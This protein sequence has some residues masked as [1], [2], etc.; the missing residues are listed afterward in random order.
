MSA[1]Q[2]DGA[3][4]PTMLKRK[5]EIWAE[6]HAAKTTCPTCGKKL[7]FRSL[8]WKHVCRQ[9]GVTQVLLDTDLAEKRRAE[10]QQKAMETL[11]ARLRQRRGEPSGEQVSG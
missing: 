4:T 5:S 8:R 11:G 10:L 9:R 2:S 7:S 6:V 3:T 1:V